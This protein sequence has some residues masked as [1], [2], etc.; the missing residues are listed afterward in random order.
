MKH[1]TKRKGINRGAPRCPYCGN[2]TVLRSADGIYRENS[3]QEMLYVCK[4][5]PVCDAYVRVQKGTT[6]PLGTI[7]NREL[8][9]LR[10]K[11]H[12]Q[13]DK[14][15]KCGYMSKHDAY[16]WLGNLLGVPAKNAHI[17]Q[18]NV[19]SCNLVIRE[20]Q[21]QVEWYRARSQDN[22]RKHQRKDAGAL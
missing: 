22:K 7:A 3:R 6:I 17:A 21:K 4:K 19:L 18:L 15:Y 16:Q 2:H 12:Q 13:F 10:I 1:H 20:A 9:E 14:L 8:R 11:A 5:Y